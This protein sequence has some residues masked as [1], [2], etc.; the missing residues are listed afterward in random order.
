MV[1][2]VT[3]TI[4]VAISVVAL[5]VFLSALRKVLRRGEWSKAATLGVV[6]A[7]CTQT[8]INVVVTYLGTWQRVKNVYLNVPWV[9]PWEWHQVWRVLSFALGAVATVVFLMRVKRRDVPLNTPAVLVAMVALISFASSL[10]HG[11]N[12]FRP[13]SVVYVVLL[14]ACTVAP[15]GLGINVGVATFGTIVALACG[16]TF[17]TILPQYGFSVEPCTRDKC[18]ILNFDFTG[19]MEQDNPLAMYL[20]LAMPFVYIGFGAWEGVTLSAYILGLILLTGSRSGTTAGVITFIA[21]VVL[22]PNIRRP[23]AAPI[24][25]WLLY[26]GLTAAF[27]AGIVVPF[28]RHDPSAFTF[29]AYLWSLAREAMSDPAVLWYGTGVRGLEHVHADGLVALP[30]YSVHNQWL[31]VLFSTGLIGFALLLG[32]LALMLWNARGAYTLVVGTVLLPAFVLAVTERPW[33][34]DSLDWLTWVMP[35]T[36]LSYPTIRGRGHALEAGSRSNLAADQRPDNAL[37]AG[38]GS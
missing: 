31:Q 27:V 6:I 8:S 24:R 14:I 38:N 3:S 4:I 9:W 17:L 20:A 29:R 11:D 16:F 1:D 30:I 7:G 21:L 12:P 37:A 15:R 28:A 34:I 26:L 10:L 13:V 23:T 19:V 36:L 32:A 5:L 35:A 33:P 25:S 2:E 18:G 22:R